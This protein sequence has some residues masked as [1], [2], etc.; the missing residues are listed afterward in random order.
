VKNGWEFIPPLDKAKGEAKSPKFARR[1]AKIA[2]ESD[3]LFPAQDLS[4]AV[5]PAQ[6]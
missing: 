6:G 3:R 2:A 4:Q 5:D 1:F